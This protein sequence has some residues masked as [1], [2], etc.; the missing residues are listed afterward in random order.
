MELASKNNA[1]SVT[2]ADNRMR[3]LFIVI[4]NPP[5]LVQVVQAVQIDQTPSFV[6]PHIAGEERGRGLHR[7]QRL[8]QLNVLSHFYLSWRQACWT[9]KSF[10]QFSGFAVAWSFS[11]ELRQLLGH[12]RFYFFGDEL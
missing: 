10:D 1:T 7:A 6:L 5:L 3:K 9:G 2:S 8:N 12:H 4:A 11:N